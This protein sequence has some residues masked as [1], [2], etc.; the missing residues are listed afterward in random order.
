[1]SHPS[2]PCVCNS[3][4]AQTDLHDATD[5][6]RDGRSEMAALIR[7]RGVLFCLDSAH[8][9][10]GRH[11]GWHVA[12]HDICFVCSFGWRRRLDTLGSM[13]G[14]LASSPPRAKRETCM[15]KPGTV[16]PLGK[17]S[18]PGRAAKILLV[19]MLCL[20]GWH[21]SPPDRDAQSP[22][23]SHFVLSPLSNVSFPRPLLEARQS[24]QARVRSQSILTCITS[25]PI[26]SAK[27]VLR[28]H[29]LPCPR[30]PVG[31]GPPRQPQRFVD[32]KSERTGFGRIADDPK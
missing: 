20:L 7:T 21:P 16:Y 4:C 5:Q 6:L 28:I 26:R 15:G 9:D 22:A 30:Q 11:L 3:Q 12:A 27:M 24:L 19:T 1:M 18:S 32:G 29:I 17:P 13:T 10:L 2:P 25:Y 14:R 8:W 23:E 31:S